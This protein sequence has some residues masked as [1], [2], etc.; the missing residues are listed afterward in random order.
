M[1][2]ISIKE[3]SEGAKDLI[4]DEIKL[5]TDLQVRAERDMLLLTIMSHKMERQNQYNQRYQPKKNSINMT[6]I[7]YKSFLSEF[8]QMQGALRQWMNKKILGK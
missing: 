7:E 6:D 3:D 8:E 4:Y 2:G 5:V 1:V